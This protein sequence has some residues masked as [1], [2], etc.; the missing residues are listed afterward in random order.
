MSGKAT[1]PYFLS[2]WEVQKVGEVKFFLLP[3]PKNDSFC[4]F[5]RSEKYYFFGRGSVKKV[6]EVKKKIIFLFP[7]PKFIFGVGSENK[8]LF[9]H[10]GGILKSCGQFLEIFDPP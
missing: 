7:L 5:C 3:P 1:Q 9:F 4:I 2:L 8:F 10:L 6:G